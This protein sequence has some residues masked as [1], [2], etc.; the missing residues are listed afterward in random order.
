MARFALESPQTPHILQL[1]ISSG[2]L[3]KRAVPSAFC[4]R[5]GLEA[6]SHAHP[7]IHGGPRK[8]ILVIA[9][10]VLERLKADGYPVYPGALGENITTQGLDLPALRIGD[11]LQAGR[12]LLEVTQPRGPCTQLDV[13]G[14]DIKDAIFD[15]EVRRL[16]SASPRWGMSG[17]YMCVLE[18]AEIHCGDVIEVLA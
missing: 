8:A 11:R 14:P 13:Y 15:E 2:G 10:E 16:E 1:S 12:A 3:P 7:T 9:S 4:G 6:D 18:E 17:L 5:L